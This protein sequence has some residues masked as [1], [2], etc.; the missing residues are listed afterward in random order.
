MDVLTHCRLLPNNGIVE[1]PVAIASLQQLT[2]LFVVSLHLFPLSFL[3]GKAYAY[4]MTAVTCR[5]MPSPALTRIFS[6]RSSTQCM[7]R[8]CPAP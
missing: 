7:S 5:T 3:F 6:S 1:P 2:F 4:S 8:V